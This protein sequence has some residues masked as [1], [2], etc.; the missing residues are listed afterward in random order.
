[1]KYDDILKDLGEF[2]TY[3]KRLYVLLCI[4]MVSL[5]IQILITVFTLGVPDHRCA[6]PS[7]DN[8]TYAIQ[9]E[10]H[11]RAVNAAIPI[12]SEGRQLY[13]SCLV[14]NVINSTRSGG[15]QYTNATHL[16]NRWVYDEATF[17]S[18]IVTTFDWV[19]DR[20]LY[21]SH[22]QML[23]MLGSLVSCALLVPLSDV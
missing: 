16:C 4:P 19:C 15:V 7:L 20:K 3:Q 17:G 23:F 6:V 18:N 10:Q 1:M 11:A 22:I 2:G 13:S 9:G 14:Y 21:K 8:D 5:G 12:A